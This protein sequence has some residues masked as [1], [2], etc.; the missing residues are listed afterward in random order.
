MGV[1]SL[2][3]GD[4]RNARPHVGWWGIKPVSLNVSG[5]FD[6]ARLVWFGTMCGCGINRFLQ[7]C[8]KYS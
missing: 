8:W 7:I 2:L 3:E 4:R 6:V 5:G 1:C